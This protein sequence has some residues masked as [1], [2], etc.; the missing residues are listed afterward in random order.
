MV[1]NDDRSCNGFIFKVFLDP[2]DE[3]KEQRLTNIEPTV[4]QELFSFYSLLAR[5]Y[6]EDQYA[7]GLEDKHYEKFDR[8][9]QNTP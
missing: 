4:D 6:V 2:K 9:E 1:A 5:C 3:I 7:G 8:I